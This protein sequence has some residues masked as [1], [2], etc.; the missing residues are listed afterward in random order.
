VS[1]LK[2]LALLTEEDLASLGVRLGPRKRIVFKMQHDHK[3]KTSQG[4]SHQGSSP[5]VST[6]AQAAAA[7]TEEAFELGKEHAAKMIAQRERER[8]GAALGAAR[9]EENKSLR[10]RMSGWLSKGAG[11]SASPRPASASSSSSTPTFSSS[12]SVASKS[13]V[14]LRPPSQSVGSPSPFNAPSMGSFRPAAGSSRPPMGSSRPSSSKPSKDAAPQK[15]DSDH[16][17]PDEFDS[18]Q[19]GTL[20]AFIVNGLTQPR[21][22]LVTITR[23]EVQCSAPLRKAMAMYSYE[24]LP[25]ARPGVM[26]ERGVKPTLRTIKEAV[27]AAG[28]PW[29]WAPQSEGPLQLL[30]RARTDYL[31]RKLDDVSLS[32]SSK[33]RHS[34]VTMRIGGGGR[35]LDY[36]ELDAHL[37]KTAD[38]WRKPP[39]RH[40]VTRVSLIQECLRVDPS[41][42]GYDR[43]GSSPDAV[44][45]WLHGKAYSFIGRWQR[46]HN[47]VMAT[48][49][50]TAQA[51]PPD[52][53]QRWEQ[54]AARCVAARRCED[55]S[56][57]G[58]GRVV[59]GDQTPVTRTILGRMTLNRKGSKDTAVSAGGSE[60]ERWTLMPL[61]DGFGN[62]VGGTATFHGARA[63]SGRAEPKKGTVAREL[64]HWRANGYPQGLLYSCNKT[65]WFTAR[66]AELLFRLLRFHFKTLDQQEATRLS[67]RGAFVRDAF[68]V[69]K[70]EIFASELARMDCA[71]IEIDER[72]TKKLQVG[73][74]LPHKLIKIG[75]RAKHDA[76]V[77]TQT[78]DPVTGKVKPPP[79]SLSAK[80]AMESI[81]AIP[82]RT[83]VRC[84]IA[85]KTMRP[86]D[87]PDD[88]RKDYDLDKLAARSLPDGTSLRDVIDDPELL[89]Q[90][91]DCDSE[92]EDWLND[93]STAH[94]ENDEPPSGPPAAAE[95]EAAAADA[96]DSS[97]EEQ[98][99]AGTKAA[100]AAAADSSDEEQAAA[101]TK[102]AAAAD[103]SDEELGDASKG[104]SN[105]DSSEDSSDADSSEEVEEADGQGIC[106]GNDRWVVESLL[107]FRISEGVKAGDVFRKGTHLYKCKWQGF[108]LEEASW[109]PKSSIHA[110]LI[111][112]FDP[113]QQRE[114][115]V[116][117]AAASGAGSS[118]KRI[119][120]PAERPSPSAKSPARK[121]S[122]VLSSDFVEPLD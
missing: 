35:P 87:Y 10:G 93:R 91:E 77:L 39:N 84:F 113:F 80:W 79:R 58:P 64:L 47:F 92:D 107:E 115:S 99:A 90:V 95:T 97:D 34:R 103:S 106:L 68:S 83:L 27:A 14:P 49:H 105:D 82:K 38:Q 21:A 13:S 117:S 78:R 52:F 17:D 61:W 118:Q 111:A 25:G 12:A 121:R 18:L 72:M 76:Y 43:L 8:L 122:V 1:D 98:A 19:G 96:A 110:E 65:A 109:E 55:G 28:K 40:R 73:D 70:M 120:E 59:V 54:F 29:L 22:K 81:L 66:E 36:P 74:L 45:E 6:A 89:A 16:S 48:I 100:A 57:L 5:G 75:C 67:P 4:I 37:V 3:P 86:E 88:L 53:A 2:S 32:G 108:P 33:Y 41:F 9:R 51:L 46:R 119:H 69:H 44:H 112:A 71:E 101:G 42:L 94:A 56:L 31:A 60:K 26:V 50:S 114:P 7:V 20:L 62:F 23:S 102:A 30:R 85:T 24:T 11:T 104:A 63:P 15:S 116:G